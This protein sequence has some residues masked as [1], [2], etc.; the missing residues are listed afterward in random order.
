MSD[1][2]SAKSFS[3]ME[4]PTHAPSWGKFSPE[5]GGVTTQS[6]GWIDGQW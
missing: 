6:A 4:P 3:S 5:S 1:I 2:V